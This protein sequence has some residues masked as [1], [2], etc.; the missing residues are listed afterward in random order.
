[1]WMQSGSDEV[2][3]LGGRV[4]K[5]KSNGFVL[6][7]NTDN[8][9]QINPFFQKILRPHCPGGMTMLSSTQMTL[10]GVSHGSAFPVAGSAVVS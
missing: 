7:K 5:F 1:M 9:K 8:D 4:Q 3:D 6:R 2:L 10:S